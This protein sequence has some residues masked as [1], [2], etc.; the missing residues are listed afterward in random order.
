MSLQAILVFFLIL[1]L[2]KRLRTFAPSN[3]W[4]KKL[5]LGLYAVIALFILSTILNSPDITKWVWH[6]LLLVLI[7]IMYKNQSFSFARM[8]LIAIAPAEFVFL[9]SDVIES[10]FVGWYESLKIYLHFGIAIAM[11]WMVAQLIL[12]NRQ[13][14]AALKKQARRQEEEQRNRVIAARKE[15]L[16]QL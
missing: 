6:I 9:L 15:E 16:E 1:Y 5:T 13:R 10:F 4:D 7:G 14:K 8:V 11:T 2:R 3:E 12:S